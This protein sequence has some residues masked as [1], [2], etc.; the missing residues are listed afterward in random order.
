MAKVDAEEAKRLAFEQQKELCGGDNN[1]WLL[2]VEDPKRLDPYVVEAED[3]IEHLEL[4]FAEATVL[5]SI[6]RLAKL[7]QG[8]GKP[9]SSPLY[10]AEKV[11]YYG[12]R[13]LAIVRR[14]VA[15]LKRQE[16]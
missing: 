13:V 11:E 5:K 14:Y 12:K 7:R 9:G 1:Y 3:L 2:A 4:N 10:E 8:L 6:W 16:G 15:K